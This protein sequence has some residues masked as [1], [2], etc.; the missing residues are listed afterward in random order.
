MTLTIK[1]WQVIICSCIAAIFITLLSTSLVY[2]H[3]YIQLKS[4][5]EK[6][7][8]SKLTDKLSDITQSLNQLQHNLEEAQTANKIAETKLN[9]LEEYNNQIKERI[10]TAIQAMHK[11][12][13]ANQRGKMIA[14]N[15]LHVFVLIQQAES[16]N[17]NIEDTPTN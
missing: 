11:I 1:K 6:V 3:K 12:T 9:N 13:D 2:H 8:D 7:T 5:I 17:N 4:A 15:L 16:K 10:S 14:E